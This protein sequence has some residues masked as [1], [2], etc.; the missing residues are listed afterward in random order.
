VTI[1]EGSTIADGTYIGPY[2][3][4][5]PNSRIEGTHVENSVIIGDSIITTNGR[6]IDSLIGRSA[7]VKS[8]EGLL[9]EGRR[10]VVGENSN[11]NL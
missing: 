11:L 8:A 4:V 9:P 2:T 6:L 10:L 5:G 3:S 1:A 7:E